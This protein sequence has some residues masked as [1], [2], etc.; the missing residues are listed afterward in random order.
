MQ[1]IVTTRNCEIPTDVREAVDARF[2]HLQRFETRASRAE[3]V[4]TG[5]KNRVRVEA[6][7][8][9]DRGERIHGE[10]EG[11]DAR[12]ALDRLTQKLSVQ[13]RRS[14]ERHHAHRAPPMD[15]LFGGPDVEA[16]EAEETE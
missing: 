16:P 10:G 2:D 4:F 5:E 7:V 9:I 8:S 15:E 14:H 11:P 6:L 13:L 12:S 3:V 1:V